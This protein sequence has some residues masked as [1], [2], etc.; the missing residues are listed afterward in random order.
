MKKVTVITAAVA[1]MI[2]TNLFAQN[3]S[4]KE[5]RNLTND[6]MQAYK[7]QDWQLL[8]KTTKSG[9]INDKYFTNKKYKKYTQ[10]AKE[11]DGTIKEIHYDVESFMG[12]T[13]I[14]ADA[15]VAD[16]GK[17][18]NDIYAV[19]LTK[20]DTDDWHAYIEGIYTMSKSDF[21]EMDKELKIT[22]VKPVEKKEIKDK[23]VLTHNS[24]VTDDLSEAKIS[25]L[26]NHP[27]NPYFNTVQLKYNDNYL[28]AKYIIGKYLINYKENGVIYESKNKLSKETTVALFKKYLAHDTNWN[29]DVEWEKVK[30]I[31][32]K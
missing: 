10:L 16:V 26:I 17:K 21:D 12:H 29:K 19:N 20:K 2:S 23:F 30:L 22:S 4:E 27:Q 32:D 5:I 25:D 1:L 9:F 13:I 14:E 8:K 24:T 28:L 11:W 18:S 3:D 6:V 31:N 15:Y 7:T